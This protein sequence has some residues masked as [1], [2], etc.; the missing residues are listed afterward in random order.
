MRSLGV[1]TLVCGII[2]IF[3]C[4]YYILEYRTSWVSGFL[5]A[6]LIICV[7]LPFL[8][9]VLHYQIAKKKFERLGPTQEATVVIRDDDFSLTSAIGS[10]TLPWSVIKEVW[11]CNGFWLV[12]FSRRDFSTIPLDHMQP[13]EKEFILQQVQKCGGTICRKSIR[14]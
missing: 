6:V 1:S 3:A 10:V 9:Y 14:F 13:E 11:L 2:S 7:M 4:V 5:S 8:A 12:L